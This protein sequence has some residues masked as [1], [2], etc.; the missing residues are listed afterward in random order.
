MMRSSVASSKQTRC[1]DCCTIVFI[2]WLRHLN[3]DQFTLWC[4]PGAGR[5]QLVPNQEIFH[6]AGLRGIEVSWSRHVL[7]IEDSRLP[8]N[9]AVPNSQMVKATLNVRDRVPN[10]A[11]FAETPAYE[12]RANILDNNSQNICFTPSLA[13]VIPLCCIYL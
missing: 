3:L 9:L 1:L 2:V 10:P 11:S 4:I 8:K 13:A 12:V 7:K 5:K 6:T